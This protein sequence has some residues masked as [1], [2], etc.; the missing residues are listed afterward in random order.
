MGDLLSHRV[1]QPSIWYSVSSNQ[2]VYG[3]QSSEEL[4]AIGIAITITS[5]CR[6]PFGMVLSA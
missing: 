5:F 4:S 6:L 1:V 3:E 2:V